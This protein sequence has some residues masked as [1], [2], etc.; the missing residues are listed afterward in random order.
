MDASKLIHQR[1]ILSEN[2]FVEMVVWNVP[3]A[4]KGSDHHY[5]YRLALVVDEICVLRYD[6]ESGKGD[7][8]HINGQ[9]IE[10]TFSNPRTLLNDFWQD[11]E[12]WRNENE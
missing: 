12:L 3:T 6:N 10:Y 11:I 7:H 5:K 1:H 2:T 8:K 9:E 4:V